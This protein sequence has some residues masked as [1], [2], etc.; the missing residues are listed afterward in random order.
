MA[1]RKRDPQGAIINAADMGNGL[2]LSASEVAYLATD[3]AIRERA[4]T[5]TRGSAGSLGRRFAP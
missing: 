4:L 2:R 5:V 1:K 3:D